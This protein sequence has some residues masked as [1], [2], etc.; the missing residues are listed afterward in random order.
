M[1]GTGRYRAAVLAATCLLTATS[2]AL[3]AQSELY[4]SDA[5]TITDTSVRQGSFTA[6]ALSHDTIVS[7]YP[8][9]GREMRFRF[10]LNGQDNEFRPGTEHTVY[11][12]PR[13]GRIV[14]PLYVFGQESPPYHP[15]P[16]QSGSSEEGIAQVTIRLDL[17][18]VLRSFREQG[19]YDPPQGT[20]I[21]RED[22]QS[23]YAIGDTEP[24]SWDVRTLRPGSPAEL[25]D[26]DGDGIFAATVPVRAEYTRAMAPD[27]RAIW[28]RTRDVSQFP[29]LESGQRL[30]D[31]LYRMSLEELQQ[32]VRE[33]G[34]LSAG[35]K[36]PGVWTRDVAYA[37]VLG[38]ALV[39]PDAVRRSLLA[40]VDSAGRIIQ[41][42]G[43]GGSWPVSTDRMT[44]ALAAWELYAATGDR[45]WLRHAYDVIRRSAEADLHA[46][47]DP[48]T[49]LAMGETSFM[50]WRE[51][52]YPRWMEPR[53]IARSAGVGTNAVHYA[54]YRI[55]AN[56]AG[57][58]GEDATG[59]SG[60]AERLREA[61]NRH[62]WL[63]DRGWYANFRYGR[64]FQSLVP[65]SD[66]LG[67]ALSIIYGVPDRQRSA[68]IADSTPVVEFGT[69]IFWPYVPNTPA[70][71]NAAIWPFVTAFAAWAAAEAGHTGA[72]EHALAA[73]YRPAALFLTNKENM[74]AATGHFEGTALNSDRQLWSVA[75]NLATHYRVLFGIR[76]EPERLVLR[77]MV[78]PGYGGTRT[79]DGL[80]YRGATI[81]L[82]VRGFGNRVERARLDGQ[83][84][85]VAAIP[86]TLTGHHTMEI[87]MN[88]QWP[89]ARMNV[90]DNVT[91]PGTPVATLRGD[92]LAWPHVP[93]AAQYTV[94]RDGRSDSLTLQ[95][96]TVVRPGE[97]L[98]ELQVAAVDS[99][100]VAS[101][102][103]EPVRLVP[104]AVVL[105]AK[106]PG[107]TEREHGGFTGSGY[108][109]LTREHNTTV[110]VQVNIREGGTYVIEA[111][112]ANGSGPVNTDS[113]AA[114]RTLL[115]DGRRAGVL[116]MP[117][118]G[119]GL[120][121]DWGYSTQQQ[122][123][124]GPG[125]HT[126]T[127]TYAQLDENMDRR[128]NTALLDHLRLTLL[129]ADPA[130]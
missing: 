33:D 122:V 38:L 115:T 17:R 47:F 92:T 110:A 16:E 18:H 45:Q 91:A 68:V 25:T 86:A 118:R 108:V 127:L 27:G 71:H 22:L 109:T 19:F 58:L 81:T 84:V 8:R 89:A 94:R 119:S 79:L 101:F 21:R 9:S 67:E 5:Y 41:D 24:L 59:W 74:V 57:A 93:G 116:V 26:A 80:R 7:T 48:A 90:V 39:A 102:L 75:G 62:L 4:R 35:A 10:S 72:V 31:A 64:T 49:G 69:P 113:K 37:S 87:E 53:D 97:G 6:V 76:L 73:V 15:T 61:I 125:M 82:T 88:G 129:S 20:R 106:P 2:A 1:T 111:R 43:T 55:L 124:L 121:A 85:E 3:G 36:W 14:T 77:P 65:R 117:Q 51:Q 34:A 114:V 54:T 42:T 52:S 44:W 29:Q 126:V 11:I 123:S 30:L 128:I 28:A 100:G 50:D 70:Y 83:A 23:V 99:S 103:S 32:L 63:E 60:V 104:E 95:T 66:G 112:Y 13:D 105:V 96:W 12:R 40:K 78:P 107:A 46:I 98:S 120:W 56:M 130:N